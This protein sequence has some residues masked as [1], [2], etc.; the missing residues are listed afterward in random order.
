MP[1]NTRVAQSNY[2]DVASLDNLRK[3]AQQDEKKALEKVAK[4]F[5]GIFM[6]MLLKSMREANKAFESDSPLNSQSSETYRNMYDDQM[7]LDLSQ[8]GSLGLSELIVQQLSPQTSNV[9]PAAALRTQSLPAME[10]T[11]LKTSSLD[12]DIRKK[13]E[14]VFSGNDYGN[15]ASA[16]PAAK[17]Q[18]EKV[19][20]SAN[21]SFTSPA[22]FVNQLMPYAKK[23]AAAL[24]GSPSVLIAQAALETGWGQKIVNKPSQESSFNLFNI[25]AD[26]RWQ[27]EH[28]TVSTL[29]YRDGVAVREKAQFRAYDGLE[30]SFDDF[31]QFL[32]NSPRYQPALEKISNPAS[33]LQGLQQ[34]GYATDPN[35]A[36]KIMS[37]LSRVN[38][39][40]N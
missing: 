17:S 40:A 33:F 39:L 22:D 30:Q 21:P 23:A 38:Q 29:E 25:K 14:R 36:S 28:A 16:I 10:A 8:N 31:T 4:Q 6:K 34:A 26:N 11:S 32:Q 1:S 3:E 15:L 19:E 13:I 27:G 18:P 37:V 24:G 20:Q 35:Y 9:M 7:A 2:Q 12:S 5:E